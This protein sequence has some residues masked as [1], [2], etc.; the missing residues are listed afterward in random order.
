MPEQG[1][2]VYSV[3]FS[4]DGQTLLTGGGD[5]TVRLYNV[6]DEKE[7]RQ[8]PGAEDA[9]YTVTFHPDGK[10]IAAAGLDKVVRMW[11]VDSGEPSTVY[12][13]ARGDIY[14][15]LYNNDG[16]QLMA[17]TYAANLAIWKTADG[18]LHYQTDLPGRTTYGAAW[19]PNT[20]QIAIA[21][22]DG[23]VYLIDL[24]KPA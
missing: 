3:A 4:P 19:S 12:S 15:V 8:F 17:V 14:R 7:L 13:G 9:V 5:K 11:N 16:S 1:G 21:A 6:A 2:P 18:K 10:T 22:E 20:Q 23:N 24:P